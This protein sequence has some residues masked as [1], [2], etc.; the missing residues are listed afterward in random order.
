[1]KYT[2]HGYQEEAVAK[3]LEDKRTLIKAPTGAGKTLVGVEAILQAGTAVNLVIGPLHTL[4]GWAKVFEKQGGTPLRFIDA[5]KAGRL[6]HEDLAMGVPGNYFIGRERFRGQEWK[7]WDIDF[8]VLDEC[9][10]FTNHKSVGFKMLKTLK[11]EYAIAQSATPAGNNFQGLYAVT[12]WLYPEFTG[13]AYY[14][15]LTKW[16]YT[17]PDPHAYLKVVGEKVP[18]TYLASVPSYVSM[19][20]VYKAEPN[21]FEIDVELGAQQRKHYKE[22]ERDSITFLDDNPLLTEL[23]AVRYMRLLQMT[24]AVPTVTPVW[25]EDK[26]EFRDHVTFEDGAKSAKA[27]ALEDLLGDL[28]TKTVLVYTHSKQYATY[29]T[30]RLQAKGHNARQWIGGMSQVERDWK[31]ENFGKEF[32]IMVAT[33]PAIGEGVDGLQDVCHTEVWMS[34]SDNRYLNIQAMGRLSRQGQEQ[35]VNR[36]VIRAKDTVELTKQDPRIKVDSTILESSFQEA[37]Q[38]ADHA[39]SEAAL[40]MAGFSL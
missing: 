10:S 30:K 8:C 39:G 31:K 34:V 37:V 15:W 28:D 14:K 13:K 40:E 32:D 19:P 7:G 5:R 24:L 1:M 9:Q 16:A 20:S 12:H 23:P 4:T 2:L 26:G 36:Y 38:E 22:M 33:L 27:D 25:D 6:A 3:V 18:G 11:T 21:I 17:E 29:L 35:T